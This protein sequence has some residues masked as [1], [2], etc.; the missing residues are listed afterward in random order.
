MKVADLSLRPRPGYSNPVP[1]T[2]TSHADTA[3]DS[4][5]HMGPDSI[6][7]PCAHKGSYEA[8]WDPYAP[9]RDHMGPYGTFTGLTPP[10]KFS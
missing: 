4:W 6:C 7:V 5:I 3:L 1:V 10:R 9:I 8:I 2:Q